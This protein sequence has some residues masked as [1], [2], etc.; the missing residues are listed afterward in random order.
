MQ[1]FCQEL[2][3]ILAELQFEDA[4]VAVPSLRGSRKRSVASFAGRFC[5]KL[6]TGESATTNAAGP[7]FA[8]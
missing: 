4:A 8:V 7:E 6:L 5:G 2:Q 3:E 1:L